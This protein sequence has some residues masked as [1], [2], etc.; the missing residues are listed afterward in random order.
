M[1]L[2]DKI[3]CN[4]MAVREVCLAEARFRL[5]FK[6]GIGISVLL[7][8]PMLTGMLWDMNRFGDPYLM[9]GVWTGLAVGLMLGLRLFFKAWRGVKELREAI[10]D[11]D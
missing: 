3:D 11:L 6:V 10:D 9:A 1:Y 4:R 7:A 8:I 5:S 2:L